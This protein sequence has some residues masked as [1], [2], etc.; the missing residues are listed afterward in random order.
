MVRGTIRTTSGGGGWVTIAPEMGYQLHTNLTEPEAEP[1]RAHLDR[2]FQAFSK[3]FGVAQADG[4][5]MPV[6]L[7]RTPWQYK[8]A[9]RQHGIN[10]AHSG[11][12][13]FRTDQHRA[14]A[15]F[16][17]DRGY[18]E[19]FAVLQHEGFHQ[20]AD[21]RFGE[22]LPL[23][24]NE[25]LAQYFED[26]LMVGNTFHVGLLNTYRLAVVQDALAGG[27]LD[28]LRDMLSVD[29]DKLN[30]LLMHN[31][32][33]AY[34]LYGVWWSFVIF[35]IQG[36]NGAHLPVV[37]HALKQILATGQP[38]D[39]TPLSE[40]EQSWHAFLRQA[41]PDPLSQTLTRM[42][43]LG[44]LMTLMFERERRQHTMWEELRRRARIR[45][46]EIVER[47]HHGADKTY[48]ADD[49]RLYVYT[50]PDGQEASFQIEPNDDPN[51]PAHV[52]AA[53]AKGKPRLIWHRDH[54]RKVMPQIVFDG[55]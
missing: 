37:H 23:W 28:E 39:I 13:Y 32:V 30:Q 44:D 6:Y 24:L 10:T 38:Q 27:H 53:H 14:L 19:V 54:K 11:G 41:E 45:Q 35:L 25:G 4:P 34:L 16:F 3:R 20:F 46:I 15:T 2:V 8:D 31:P 29:M 1:F 43:V 5:P 33:R 42:T 12:L 17:R 51:L 7:Y 21:D 40:L 48:H 22:A 47:H 36:D 49:E 18:H 52:S 50:R 9:L 55:G 26:G